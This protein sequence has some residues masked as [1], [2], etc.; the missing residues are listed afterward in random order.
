MAR[1]PTRAEILG[2]PP[3][4]PQDWYRRMVDALLTFTGKNADGSRYIPPIAVAEWTVVLTTGVAAAGTATRAAPGAGW[5][6]VI[7]GLSVSYSAAQIG[8]CTVW[9]GPVDTGTLLQR[10]YV[11]S[12]RDVEFVA[13]VPLP[14]NTDLNARLSAGG[15]GVTGTVDLRGYTIT[16]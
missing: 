8:E 11:H 14:E 1:R 7:T 13:P 15:V 4:E 10:F 16:T 9:A 12:Q 3:D 2:T 6:L 5:A